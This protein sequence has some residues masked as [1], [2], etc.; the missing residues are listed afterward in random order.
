M[1]TFWEKE[2]LCSSDLNTYNLGSAI[3]H[4]LH[5]NDH[6]I[7]RLTIIEERASPSSE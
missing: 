2:V 5:N 7:V 3:L 1:K 6:N 4:F